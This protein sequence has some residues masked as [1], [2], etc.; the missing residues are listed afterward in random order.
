MPSVIHL[1]HF[2]ICHASIGVFCDALLA[3]FNVIGTWIAKNRKSCVNRKNDAFS[4][5]RAHCAREGALALSARIILA[6]TQCMKEI[7]LL[8]P[9][10]AAVDP[11]E[12]GKLR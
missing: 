5:G 4:G 6:K 1:S 10:P 7:Q 11:H 8:V 9:H 3:L 2:H 12:I